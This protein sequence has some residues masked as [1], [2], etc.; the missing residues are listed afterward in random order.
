MER[1]RQ[2]PR[3]EGVDR[4]IWA[5]LV[6]LLGRHRR[7]LLAAVGLAIVSQVLL[8][9]VPLVQ[10]VIFDDTITS[11][12]RSRTVWISILL[13]RVVEDGSHDELVES[14]GRYSELWA[15]FRQS[16]NAQ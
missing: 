2:P 12:S 11:D 7:P 3:R 5:D 10:K 6:P 8:S 13:G 16:Q 14:G 15:A 1:E 9:L 4:S